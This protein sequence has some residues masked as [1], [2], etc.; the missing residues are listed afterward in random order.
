MGEG[1]G[2]L[3]IHQLRNVP[4]KKTRPTVEKRPTDKESKRKTAFR[5]WAKNDEIPT[6]ITKTGNRESENK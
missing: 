1:R 6:D 3:T 4:I 5:Y 2:S